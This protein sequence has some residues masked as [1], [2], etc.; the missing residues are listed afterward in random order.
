ME[1]N[2]CIFDSDQLWCSYEVDDEGNHVAG[3]WDYCASDC[4][5]RTRTGEEMSID[6]VELELLF[7]VELKLRPVLVGLG[8]Q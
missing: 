1:Y 5:G 7:Q 4:P 3:S 2:R 6:K 8:I